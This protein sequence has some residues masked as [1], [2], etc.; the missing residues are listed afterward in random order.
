MHH[1]TA[2]GL[3]CPT[4]KQT[5]LKTTLAQEPINIRLVQLKI[6]RETEKE[7]RHKILKLKLFIKHFMI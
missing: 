5:Y 4:I 1:H 7:K 2:K 6:R 3:R